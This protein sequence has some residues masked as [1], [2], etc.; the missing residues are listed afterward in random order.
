MRGCSARLAGKSKLGKRSTKVAVMW[1]W[2]AMSGTGM[3]EGDEGV[4]KDNVDK[5]LAIV[6]FG[7]GLSRI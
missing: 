1:K 2:N 4:G 7:V 6:K 3:E 5:M